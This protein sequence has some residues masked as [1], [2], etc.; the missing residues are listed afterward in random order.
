MTDETIQVRQEDK[1]LL[2]R[3]ALAGLA[4]G[5]LALAFTILVPAPAGL[6]EAGW[7]VLGLALL[8]AVWWSTEPVPMGVTALMPLIVMPLLGIVDLQRAAAAYANPLIFPFLGGFL[9]AAAIRRWGLH[10]R[11]AHAAVR[12]IGTEPRRLLLGFMAATGFLSMWISNTSAA[13]LMLPVAL[14]IV[15]AMEEANGATDQAR[16]FAQALLL[17]LAYGASIGGIGTLI[18]TPPNALLAG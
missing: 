7:R 1:P 17:G 16:R 3:G 15:A 18:G 2:G 6:P 11:M 5:A 8:M 9:L 12:A 14:S 4:A 10:R 13:L